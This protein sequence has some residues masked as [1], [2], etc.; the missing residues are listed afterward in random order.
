MHK[1]VSILL[2]HEVSSFLECY[3]IYHIARSSSVTAFSTD[4]VLRIT[5]DEL[6]V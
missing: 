4:M 5:F 1:N 6:Q 3:S 2:Y